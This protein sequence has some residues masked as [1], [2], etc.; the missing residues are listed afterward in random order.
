VP[1]GVRL[2]TTTTKLSWPQVTD[3][4]GDP[5]LFYRIYR[6]GTDWINDYYGRTTSGTDTTFTDSATNGDIHTYYVVAVDSSYME[7]RPMGTIT[8]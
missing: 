8:K 6:D 3:P 4:D 2:T 1:S 5:I 7:S